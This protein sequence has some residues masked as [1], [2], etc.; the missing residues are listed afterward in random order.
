VVPG[1]RLVVLGKQGAGK[2]TQCVRLSHHYVIPHISTGDMLRAAVKAKTKLGLEAK[3]HMDAGELIPDDIVLEMVAERL[4][5]DDT[6]TRGFV[7][8]GFPRTVAQA[9][10]LEDLLA[11]ATL[12][13]AIDLEVPT[14]L[15]LA[16]LASRR[17]CEDC[18]TIYS[19][20]LPPAVDW[21]CDLC[22]GEVVQR[23]DDTEDAIRR[24]LALYEKETE[25]LI[26]FYDGQDRLV[27]VSGV[28]GPDDV[29]HRIVGE[30]DRRRLDGGFG[31]PLADGEGMR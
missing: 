14:E 18:G 26:A 3:R 27:Q 13:L 11:P 1:G 22:G 4:D 12:D 7:L 10:G 28:G 9:R 17:V 2:G 6:R 16:R 15:V 20:S 29:F 24:R 21:T 5:Q 31:P 23:P 19:V 30:V 25:P 8:D